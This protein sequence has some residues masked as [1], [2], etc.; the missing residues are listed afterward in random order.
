M[1]VAHAVTSSGRCTSSGLVLLVYTK[2]IY[3]SWGQQPSL[4]K[5]LVYLT[6]QPVVYIR[7]HF[8]LSNAIACK[9]KLARNCIN[10]RRLEKW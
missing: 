6:R 8:N 5:L 2:S 1:F 10:N 9:L 3:F 7:A 4:L